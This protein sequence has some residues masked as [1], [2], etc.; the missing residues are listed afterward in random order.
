MSTTATPDVEQKVDATAVPESLERLDFEPTC[1]VKGR[2]AGVRDNCRQPATWWALGDHHCHHGTVVEGLWCT[3][4]F[5]HLMS[6]GLMR[7]PACG[8]QIVARL[9]IRRTEALR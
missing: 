3:E 1:E 5:K 7:C 2:L 4:H 8:A 6:G 9:L